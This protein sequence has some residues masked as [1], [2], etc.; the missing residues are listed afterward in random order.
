MNFLGVLLFPFTFLYDLITRL[1]NYLY[2]TGYKRS[3]EFQTNVI[4]VGNLSVGGTGKSPMVE[5]II[6]LLRNRKLVTLSRGYGRQSRG[7]RIATEED[8]PKTIG[9]E[10]YLFYKKFDHVYV[11][12]GEQRAVAI[13][14]ILAELP[15]TE[16]IILDDAYQHRPVKP[17]LNIL[18]TD[19][20]KPFFEDH[21]LPTGRLRESRKG[22][23]RADIIVVTKCPENPDV[24]RYDLQIKKYNP[25]AHIAFSSIAYLPPQRISGTRDFCQ[26][27]F[28]VTGIANPRSLKEHIEANYRLI[29]EHYFKDHHD[30]TEKDVRLIKKE[31]EAKA[32]DVACVLTTEKDMVKLH[33]LLKK[34]EF[35][36]LPVFYLPI[37]TVFVNGGKRFDEMV[38]NSIRSYSD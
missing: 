36:G 21:I 15:D 11:T 8:T 38:L 1:R 37:E 32:K 26:N 28:L 16:V 3:F 7:F 13:P 29:G 6:R 20:T 24:H 14:F 2:D 18:L 17:S 12:V 22:A 34:G 19:Y 31:F 9:D 5:Y 25:T 30:Y 4:S 27:V 35:S 33:P 23:K 10:P